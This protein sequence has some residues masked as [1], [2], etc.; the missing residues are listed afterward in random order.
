MPN[1]SNQPSKHPLKL[2]ENVIDQLRNKTISGIEF[3]EQIEQLSKSLDRRFASPE[4]RVIVEDAIQ[5]SPWLTGNAERVKQLRSNLI[6]SLESC[7]DQAR[8]IEDSSDSRLVLIEQL[9]DVAER[10]VESESAHD[11]LLHAA[12]PGPEWTN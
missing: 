5:R 7:C 6:E 12:F 4:S 8:N 3:S 10:Y 11:E 2:I 1:E 9:S